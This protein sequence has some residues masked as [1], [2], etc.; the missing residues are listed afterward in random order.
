MKLTFRFIKLSLLQRWQRKQKGHAGN[1]TRAKVIFFLLS[2]PWL[3]RQLS[4][5]RDFPWD[6]LASCLQE[7]AE[8]SHRGTWLAE[9]EAV[10][11]Q[12]LKSFWHNGVM[13]SCDSCSQRAPLQRENK[14][15]SSVSGPTSTAVALSEHSSESRTWNWCAACRSAAAGNFN[16]IG[17]FCFTKDNQIL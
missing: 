14:S 11:S 10:G 16:L 5:F 9:D 2:F 6:C 15:N 13:S 3:V 4:G 17:S 1:K 7:G 8:V 12:K